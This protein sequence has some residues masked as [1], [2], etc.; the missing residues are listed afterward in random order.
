MFI[1]FGGTPE[2]WIDTYHDGEIPRYDLSTHAKRL[3]LRIR[4]LCVACLN[5]LSI[6]LIRPSSVISEYRDSLCYVFVQSLLVGL[7]IVPGID[8]SKDM[9]VLLTKVTELP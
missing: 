3:M 8:G 5:R 9:A 6:D 7:A 4:Q 2:G 1:S